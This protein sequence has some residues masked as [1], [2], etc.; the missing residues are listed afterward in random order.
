MC[1]PQVILV[2]QTPERLDGEDA[3]TFGARLKN[4]RVLAL[5]PNYAAE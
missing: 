2:V 5:N 3:A 4:D 1:P